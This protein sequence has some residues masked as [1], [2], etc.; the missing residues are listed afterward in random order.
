MPS[1]RL[2]IYKMDFLIVK[3]NK[4]GIHLE[5]QVGTAGREFRLIG[6]GKNLEMPKRWN[7]QKKTFCYHWIYTF[8]YLYN[9]EYFQLEFDYNDKFVKKL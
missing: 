4:I 3:N 8:K 2:K 6:T 7:N 9:G 1:G 5:P